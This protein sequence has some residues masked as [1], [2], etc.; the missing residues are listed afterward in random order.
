MSHIQSGNITD[1]P[2]PMPQTSGPGVAG[3]TA[4]AGRTA[5]NVVPEVG[6]YNTFFYTKS[7][8]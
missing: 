1:G 3:L 7:H 4:F 2:L 6:D 8:F 5:T